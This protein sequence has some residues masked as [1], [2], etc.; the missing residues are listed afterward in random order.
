MHGPT[1][2]A[3]NSRRY[4]KRT[5]AQGYKFLTYLKTTDTRLD[6]EGVSRRVDQVHTERDRSHVVEATWAAETL[7]TL[8][9][10]FH[11]EFSS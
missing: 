3:Y 2:F 11:S 8:F 4:S 6:E 5:E 9:Y 1:G 7:G 10:A